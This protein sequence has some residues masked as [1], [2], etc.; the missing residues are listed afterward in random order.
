MQ[1]EGRDVVDGLRKGVG[2]GLNEGL[3]K[4]ERKI[5]GKLSIQGMALIM[6]YLHQSSFTMSQLCHQHLWLDEEP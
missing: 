1:Q 3:M 4:T 2:W 5:K 6:S